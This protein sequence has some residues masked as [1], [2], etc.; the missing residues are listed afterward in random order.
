MFLKINID[1]FIK[2]LGNNRRQVKVLRKFL[3]NSVLSVLGLETIKPIRII[4][5]NFIHWRSHNLLKKFSLKWSYDLIFNSNLL[6][7][8]FIRSQFWI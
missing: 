4:G 3:N 8:S 7:G 1:L 2:S 5:L 6:K